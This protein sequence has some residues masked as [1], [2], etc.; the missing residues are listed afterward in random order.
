MLGKRMIKGFA[1]TWLVT[2]MWAGSS[3]RGDDWPQWMGPQ[4]DGVYRETGV[5]DAIPASGLPVRWRVPIHGGYAGPAVAN[6]R[7]YVTDYVRTA[8]E[9]RND[10]GQRMELSGRER[11]LCFD[12]RT[13]ELLWKHEYECRYHISYPAGPRATPTV[14]HGKVYT[15]GAEG[16]LLCLDAAKGDVLWSKAL[17]TEYQT[18]AP[19]WGFCGH[20]LVDGDK[21]ICLVGGEGSVVVAFDKDTGRELWKAVSAPDAGYCPPS[22]IEAAGVRQLIVWDPEKINSLHPDTGAVYWT[23]PLKPDYG[24]SIMAPRKAGNYLFASGIGRVGALYELRQDRPGIK[25]VVWTGEAKTALYATN[26]TPLIDGDT[27]YGVDCDSGL[28]MA[29]DLATGKRLWETPQPTTGER[30]GG[31][32]TAFLVKHENRYFLFSETGDLIIA[33]LTRRGYSEQGRFQ[34][35]EP[36]GECFGRDVVWSH[37]AFADRACFARNDK[38]L[39][40]VSLAR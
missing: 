9:A 30:R 38:E 20:P 1:A 11:V 34:V 16:D 27:I 36:T 3:A 7:V 33:R 25:R 22:I 13:G 35:L 19:Q 15:L 5:I 18:E 31:H 6:G 32:G 17:K 26:T 37:P 29:V 23:Q 10:P 4:R 14:A 12:A 8:G 28:L 39:V 2:V 21:L 40:C 24:M